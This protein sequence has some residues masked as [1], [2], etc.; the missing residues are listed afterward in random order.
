M[1]CYY[2][3][4]TEYFKRV[5]EI[6]ALIENK[7]I[8]KNFD[9]LLT[10]LMESRAHTS[11]VLIEQINKHIEFHREFMKLETNNIEL[12]SNEFKHLANVEEFKELFTKLINNLIFIYTD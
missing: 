8:E 2:S 4:E 3:E 12:L 11:E 5:Q 6:F 7:K 1:S 9:E 10:F